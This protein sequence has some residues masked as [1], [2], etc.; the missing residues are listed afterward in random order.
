MSHAGRRMRPI[1]SPI[2]PIAQRLEDVRQSEGFGDLKAFHAAASSA[3]PA[4]GEFPSYASARRYHFDREPPVSYLAAVASRFHYRLEWL[5]TGQE[6]ARADGVAGWLQN[7]GDQDAIAAAGFPEFAML[8]HLEQKEIR[9]L[10]E[11]YRFAT[12]EDQLLELGLLGPE[13]LFD[14]VETIP[15]L[16]FWAAPDGGYESLVREILVT[17]LQ[18][19]REDGFQ[20]RDGLTRLSVLL[21]SEE[22]RNYVRAVILALRLAIPL[23]LKARPEVELAEHTRNTQIINALENSAHGRGD[24]SGATSG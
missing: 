11:L 2:H 15:S 1:A 19:W 9:E 12:T 21:S 24:D 22:G 8:L 10:L 17:P 5:A 3:A 6:P 23:A 18:V 13:R 20:S 14:A 16:K 4:A 7:R